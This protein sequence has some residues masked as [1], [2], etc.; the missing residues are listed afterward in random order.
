MRKQI[1]KDGIAILFIISLF[2]GVM[3]DSKC[4]AQEDTYNAPIIFG[5]KFCDVRFS[6][7][8]IFFEN[9]RILGTNLSAEMKVHNKRM[10]NFQKE[11]IIVY[12][13]KKN[14]IFLHNG[15]L[16]L[17]F[18]CEKD[19]TSPEGMTLRQVSE[20]ESIN[21]SFDSNVVISDNEDIV[22]FTI[23]NRSLICDIDNEKND[24]IDG[25]IFTHNEAIYNDAAA[26]IFVATTPTCL[27]VKTEE[28]TIEI[29][30]D[31]IGLPT[32]T[33][34]TLTFNLNKKMVEMRDVVLKNGKGEKV[35]IG[36][37]IPD[38]T[39]SAY[40]DSD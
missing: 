12:L 24:E 34:P 16:L 35:V 27:F 23:G 19:P 11:A 33:N 25:I 28:K 26:G 32:M 15:L 3:V 21:N 22:I 30:Y 4:V 18:V 13:K 20:I 29:S 31:D 8:M 14:T 38:V 1:I 40:L 6:G 39:L 7:K 36:I 10:E 9:N 37:S 2:L 5:E 17:Q